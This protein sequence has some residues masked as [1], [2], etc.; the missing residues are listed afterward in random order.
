MESAA[1]SFSMRQIMMSVMRSTAEP[2]PACL[3]P[4]SP[5]KVRTTCRESG[6]QRSHSVLRVAI[7]TA[8]HSPFFTDAGG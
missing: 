4:R 1:S 5:F 2:T 6:R 8:E 7:S 3:P